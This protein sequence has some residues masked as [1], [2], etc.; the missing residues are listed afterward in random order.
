[1]VLADQ[2]H[3][4]AMIDRIHQVRGLSIFASVLNR[5]VDIDEYE[6]YERIAAKVAASMSAQIVK[7]QPEMY[8]HGGN[9]GDGGLASSVVVETDTPYRALTMRPGLIADDLL[10]GERIETIDTKR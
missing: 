7:G 1:R 9:F 5:L 6:D 3:Q 10:P 2:L 4:I 8:G